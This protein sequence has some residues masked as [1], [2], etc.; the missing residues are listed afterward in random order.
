[1]AAALGW[2]PR[3]GGLWL[4]RRL[5]D[6]AWMLLGRRRRT[7]LENVRAAFPELSLARQRQLCRRS[8]QHLGMVFVELFAVLARPLPTTLRRLSVDGLEHL[9]G[10]MEAQGRALVLTGHLGNWEL[11]S[12]VARLSGYPLTVVVRPLDAPWL[13]ALVERLRAKTGAG[14]V[15]KRGAARPLLDALRRG[16]LVAI[17]LDQNTARREGVFV[18][19]FGRPACTSKSLALLAIRTQTPVVPVFIRREDDGRHRVEV[20]PPIPLPPPNRGEEGVVELTRRCTASIEAAIR[21]TPEQWLWV[22]DR[23]RTR[24]AE[25]PPR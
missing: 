21:A 9:T 20:Q 5:G 15:A 12:A 16:G 24:P 18:P 8:C 6:L 23:W 11:L 10:V 22:H 3:S 25:E 7:A 19:F 14:F 1:M 4:G 2:L 17:L 13:N